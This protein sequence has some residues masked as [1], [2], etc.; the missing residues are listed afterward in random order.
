M[1]P[2]KVMIVDDSPFSRTI[3]AEALQE[4]GYEVVGEAGSIELLIETYENCNPDVV[5]MDIAMPYADGFEC[6]K[7]LLLHDKEAKIVLIS[8]MKDEETEQKAK[9]TG[10]SGYL[11]KPVQ[12]EDLKRVIMNILSPDSLFEK[13]Q[14]TGIETFKESLSQ[15]I[16]KMTKATVD[17]QEKGTDYKF[18]SQGITVVIGLIGRSSG[19]MII[20]ISPDSAE[21]M[22]KAILKRELKNREESINMIAEFANLV[23]GI[24]CSI[25][26]KNDKALS[27]RVTPPSIFYGHI[28]EIV[29]PEISLKSVSAISEIGQINLSIGFK[30]EN[31]L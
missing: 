18:E 19:T 26:N 8:S 10:V 30:K 25:L 24:A 3:I 5:T 15:N 7:A 9:S 27:L 31:G 16:T 1:N 4:A 22:A 21:K 14:N 11:Q 17:I 12:S 29:N 23:G 28:A 20:D 13:L 6:S 2:I